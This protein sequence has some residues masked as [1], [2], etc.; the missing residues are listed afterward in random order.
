MLNGRTVQVVVFLLRFLGIRVGVVYSVLFL[1]D[2]L[3]FVD[4][5]MMPNNSKRFFLLRFSS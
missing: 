4:V 5:A 3:L 2:E 1:S